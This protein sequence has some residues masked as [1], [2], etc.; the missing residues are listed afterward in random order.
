MEAY[1]WMKKAA[2]QGS[3]R[4]TLNLGKLVEAGFGDKTLDPLELYRRAASFGEPQGYR[5]AAR[6]LEARKDYAGSAIE[7]MRCAA[8]N[9]PD[10]VGTL[11]GA[12]QAVSLNVVKE[13]Q[14]KLASSGYYAGPIDGKTGPGLKGA[15][16]QLEL[17]GPPRGL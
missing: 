3:P 2:D 11:I 7:W 8:A 6:I 14:S 13:M 9:D 16:K 5:E 10:C 15:L 4:G 1:R 17:L 12:K